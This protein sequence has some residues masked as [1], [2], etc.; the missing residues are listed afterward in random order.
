MADFEVLVRQAQALG[1]ALAKHPVV[2]AHH[3]AQRAVRADD[4]AQK[5]LQEYQQQIN[6]MHQLEA[7][8]KPIEVADKQKLK[9]LERDMAG[10]ESLKQLMRT[11]VDYV[12][13][14]SQINSA[15]DGPLA[16]L[17]EPQA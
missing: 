3:A 13:L 5:L 2:Q 4:A 1:E 17:A 14:M 15:I 7:E 6:R 12:A 11:Q 8:Q 10:Q 9:T 16:G